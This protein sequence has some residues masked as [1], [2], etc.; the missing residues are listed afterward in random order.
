[1]SSAIRRLFPAH[2]EAERIHERG[3]LGE[4]EFLPVW[5]HAEGEEPVEDAIERQVTATIARDEGWQP[6]QLLGPVIGTNALVAFW[7]P[8]GVLHHV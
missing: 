7:R 6:L 8:I 2:D 1:M 3:V 5:A 4:V